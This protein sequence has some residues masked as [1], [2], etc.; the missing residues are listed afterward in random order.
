MKLWI[1]KSKGQ[2]RTTLWSALVLGVGVNILSSIGDGIGQKQFIPLLIAV[3][4]GIA[5]EVAIVISRPSHKVIFAKS[6][7]DL[8]RQLPEFHQLVS[9]ASELLLLGG[10]MKTLTD[11]ARTMAAIKQAV[12]EGRPIRILLMHPNGGGVESTVRA[13]RTS[14]KSVTEDDLRMEIKTSV[15]RLIDFCGPTI[16][17]SIRL[18]R[19]HPT[20]SM[21]C[22]GMKWI[23]TVYT[24][25][26]GASS[27]AIFF[28]ETQSTSNFVRGLR[29][30]FDELWRA[31][32][33]SALEWPQSF[34]QSEPP[35]EP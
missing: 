5:A 24:I 7:L 30:G 14:G 22:F 31:P 23:L 19:E 12:L 18:Y 15:G 28:T 33:S 32:T 25:G 3:I 16:Q 11:D 17:N 29:Q 13:R 2:I 35:S 8:I 10:T 34:L 27:P 4:A 1:H 26:R 9:D 6:Q 20:F 21:H